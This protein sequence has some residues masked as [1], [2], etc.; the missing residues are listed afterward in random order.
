MKA[1]GFVAEALAA[2]RSRATVA[3]PAAA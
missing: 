1:C 2:S 3:P